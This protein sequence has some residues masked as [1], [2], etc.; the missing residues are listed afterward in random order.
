MLCCIFILFSIFVWFIW[1]RTRKSHLF[2]WTKR[3]F[4]CPAHLENTLFYYYFSF[5]HCKLI[6]WHSEWEIYG[7]LSA[8][9]IIG[10][11]KAYN[12]AH[13]NS[14]IS[15]IN[16]LEFVYFPFV[17]VAKN[18]RTEAYFNLWVHSLK[19]NINVKLNQL[20]FLAY[21]FFLN[22]VK[23]LNSIFVIKYLYIC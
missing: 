14:P 10:F 3:Q 17:Q 8:C 7:N 4:L 9:D 16:K 12:E 19:K 20:L 23:Y 18:L 21:T 6:F 22:K 2:S 11:D 1:R 15:S 13:C 5:L